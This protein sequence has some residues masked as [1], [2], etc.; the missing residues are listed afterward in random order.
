MGVRSAFAYVAIT[1]YGRFFQIVR[2]AAGFVTL[3]FCTGT[4][5]TTPNPPKNSDE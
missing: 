5:P 3:W 4:R 2:L 1:P